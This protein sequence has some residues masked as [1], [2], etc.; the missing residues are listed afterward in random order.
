MS[1]LEPSTVDVSTPVSRATRQHDHQ[2]PAID[3]A[4]LDSL[5]A[6][7]LATHGVLR[8]EP[9]LQ[10]SLPRLMTATKQRPPRPGQP[11]ATVAGS[12]RITVT[13]R[14]GPTGRA[15]TQV[16]V[17]IATS[18]LASARQIASTVR[19]AI[20]DCLQLTRHQPG[21]IHVNV[22]SIEPGPAQPS[23]R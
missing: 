15:E 12:E 20:V 17:D 1:E 23:S 2:Y 16:S 10:G 21:L 22:L 6:A 18:T 7:V 14:P 5:A 4:L 3:A 8:L 11:S 19:E 9:T 13:H